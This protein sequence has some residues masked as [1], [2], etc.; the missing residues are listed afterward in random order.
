MPN[1]EDRIKFYSDNIRCSRVTRSE[2]QIESAFQR[3]VRLP[4][5][6]S[7]VIDRPKRSCRSTSTRACDERRRH[8]ETASTRTSRAGRVARQL[9]LRASSGLIVIDFIDMASVKNQRAVGKEP[10]REV[11]ETDRARVQVGRISRFGLMEMSR[12]RHRGRRS[13]R[14]PPSCARV[15]AAEVASA[16]YARWRSAFSES[17]K[18]RH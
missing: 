4:S 18:K 16:T 17:W 12:Q 2:S 10:M 6:G 7:L 13:K 8:Q 9:R 5:G 11:L 14:S 15:A 3:A 1:F